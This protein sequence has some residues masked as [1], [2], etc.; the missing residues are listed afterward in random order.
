M[1]K[2]VREEHKLTLEDAIRKFSAFPAQR[3][4][5]ADRGLL[6]TGMWAD[7]AVFDPDYV[8]ILQRSAIQTS[9]PTGCGSC[10]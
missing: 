8:A 1:R 2:Y 4:R 10:W 9:F 5:F 7:T 3:M 6:K